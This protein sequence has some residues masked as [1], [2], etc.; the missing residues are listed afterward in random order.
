MR[1]AVDARPLER[2][3]TGVGRY[4]EGLLGA[5]ATLFPE[6]EIRLLSPREV[7]LPPGLEGKVSVSSRRSGLPGTVWLQA[8]APHEARIDGCEV[9]FGPLG[10]LPV[11]SSLPGVA[12]VHDLT[13]LLFPEW[14]TL[15]NRLGFAP[16]IAST[17]RSARAIACVSTATLADLLARFPE[18]EGKA[19][20]VPNG[21]VPPGPGSTGVED[22]GIEGDYVLF[23][24]TREPRKNLGRLVQAMESIWDRR[25]EF[26]PL[27]VAGGSGWGM[28]GLARR[29]DS[30]PHAGR[31]RQLGWVSP[32]RATAL[33]R[34]ARLLAYPSLYEGF[35][36]PALEA[37]AE[38]IPVVASSSSSLPEVV[39]DV[40]LLPDPLDAGAIA[41]AIER[42]NDDETFREQARRRGPERARL[43]TWDAAA[44]AT[45]ALFAEAAA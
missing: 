11:R 15:R 34:G 35:G 24:G 41:R 2:E 19:S 29:L 16:F 44:R 5:F 1:I 10:I 21:F 27:V 26:P 43:F 40:G 12:T 30:S 18:A 17:V 33:L 28:D 7:Y 13:P 36:L 42:A 37:M 31:V 20:V 39:G 45:R 8:A 25:P 22:P 23:L 38:G 3:S 4:L 9:F 6:D 32:A 14:H